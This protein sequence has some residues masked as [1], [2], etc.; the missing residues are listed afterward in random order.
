MAPKKNVQEREKEL[1]LLLATPAG[2]FELQELASQYSTASGKL[3]PAGRTRATN[4]G[5]EFMCSP[6]KWVI[7]N[8]FQ[9]RGGGMVHGSGCTNIRG[10]A[11]SKPRP[12]TPV[13]RKSH[14]SSTR[15]TDRLIES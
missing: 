7:S 4:D 15:P 5:S 12:H 10:K 9:R 2:R 8:S 13:L 11:T 3:K 1:R 6:P 14:D